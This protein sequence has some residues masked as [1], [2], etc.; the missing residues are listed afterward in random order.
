M[1]FPHAVRWVLVPVAA[2]GSCAG[3]LTATGVLGRMSE[4]AIS[5]L[6]IEAILSIDVRVG[7]ANAA[8]AV[9]FVLVGAMVAPKHRTTVSIF[10]YAVGATVAWE[11]LKDWYFPEHHPR[12]YQ[13]S[14]V[15]M[16]L[17]LGGGLIAVL[18]VAAW[19]GRQR[20]ASIAQL[21]SQRA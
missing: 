1:T 17:T 2:M 13:P 7:L 11:G 8:A 21:A 3:S 14:L 18:M 9:L 10:L 15:P 16:W 4:R 12:A 20:R 19:T 5:P 6:T